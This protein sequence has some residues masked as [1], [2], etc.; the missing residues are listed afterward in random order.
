MSLF[1]SREEMLGEVETTLEMEC[2][3]AGELKEPLLEAFIERAGAMLATTTSPGDAARRMKDIAG[4]LLPRPPAPDGR[5]VPGALWREGE[6]IVA[7]V[8]ARHGL[9][10]DA[11]RGAGRAHAVCMA[12]FEA[13]WALYEARLADGG[14]RFSLPQ[15]GRIMGGRDHTTVLHGVRR[16]E[17]VLSERGGGAR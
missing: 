5:A 13:M 10:A 14:R 7:A 16:W 17:A 12:R 8:A 9:G 11:L 2:A 6:A 4:R 1:E 3:D 15:V